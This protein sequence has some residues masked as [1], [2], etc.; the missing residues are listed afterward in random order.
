MINI[1][2][3]EATKTANVHIT[4]DLPML[5]SLNSAWKIDGLLFVKHYSQL[6]VRPLEIKNSLNQTFCKHIMPIDCIT[7]KFYVIKLAHQMQFV[8]LFLKNIFPDIEIKKWRHSKAHTTVKFH[9]L[10]NQTKVSSHGMAI[11]LHRI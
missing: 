2:R 7:F 9:M 4:F 6:L 8:V 5:R 11:F 10:R 1:D 3:K